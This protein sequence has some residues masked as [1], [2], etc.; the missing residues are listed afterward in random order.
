MSTI[1]P[2]FSPPPPACEGEPLVACMHSGGLTV[3]HQ[4]P[5]QNAPI[6]D[7]RHQYRTYHSAQ[8]HVASLDS[9]SPTGDRRVLVASMD[10][11]EPR[12]GCN[13][14]IAPDRPAA[15]T[16]RTNREDKENNVRLH[17][18]GL[19]NRLPT[20]PLQNND[21]TMNRPQA[22]RPTPTRPGMQRSKRERCPMGW[23]QHAAPRPPTTI[24]TNTTEHRNSTITNPTNQHQ[25]TTLHYT[26]TN[27]D[28]TNQH[29]NGRAGYTNN[30]R[31]YDHRQKRDRTHTNQADHDA[32]KTAAHR[33]HRSCSRDLTVN[34][35]HASRP[36]PKQAR[37]AL[38]ETGRASN[39]LA[40][41]WC[42]APADNHTHEQ[43][44]TS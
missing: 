39:G 22:S 18:R 29:R 41:T 2:D 26:W 38:V 33:P 9:I 24:P 11:D 19:H 6:P 10:V 23:R 12:P 13:T 20:E 32:P 15:A 16:L 40:T 4:S 30:I 42:A 8:P 27:Q 5:A 43:N 1:P 36:T 35:P 3:Y 21:P 14:S 7:T 44:R 34:R 37:R 17:G 31:L 28:A 25:Q